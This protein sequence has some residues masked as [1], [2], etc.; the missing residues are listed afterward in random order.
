MTLAILNFNVA[1]SRPG[2]KTLNLDILTSIPNI[3]T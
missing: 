1:F 2:I 3:L